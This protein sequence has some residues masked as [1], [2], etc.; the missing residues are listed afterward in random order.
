M[1][2]VIDA[3]HLSVESQLVDK[4]KKKELQLRHGGALTPSDVAYIKT[5]L[6]DRFTCHLTSVQVN[7]PLNDSLR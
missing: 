1:V 4:E 6:Y 2:G 5:L 3:G 7:L